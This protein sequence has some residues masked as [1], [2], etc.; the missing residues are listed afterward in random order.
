M[1]LKKFFLAKIKAEKSNKHKQIFNFIKN[2]NKCDNILI[3]EENLKILGEHSPFCP[4]GAPPLLI[5]H[6]KCP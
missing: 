1:T 4:A 3:F 5:S 6:N 2:C